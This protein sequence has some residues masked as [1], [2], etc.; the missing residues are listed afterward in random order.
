MSTK[1]DTLYTA[2]NNTFYQQVS[3]ESILS[4][5]DTTGNLALLQSN[6]NESRNSNP[7]TLISIKLIYKGNYNIYSDSL[8]LS[9]NMVLQGYGASIVADESTTANTFINIL[10]GSTN[11]SINNLTL[12]GNNKLL[13]GIYASRVNRVN[14]DK[15]TVSGTNKSG[16]LL[17]GVNSNTYNNE[18]T[19]TRCKIENNANAIDTQNVTQ[20]ICMDNTC[21]NCNSGIYIANSAYSTIINNSLSSNTSIGIFLSASS[22]ISIANNNIAFNGIG[23]TNPSSSFCNIVNNNITNSKTGILLNG[24]SNYL[25][26]NTFLNNLTSLIVSPQASTNNR[27]ITIAA[28]LTATNQRYFYPPTFNNFHNDTKII[29]NTN[30]TDIITTSNS[31][32]SIQTVYDNAVAANP[33]NTI[34][35]KLQAPIVYGDKTFIVNSNTCIVLQDCTIFLNSTTTAFSA[36]DK[37]FLSFSGGTINGLGTS[38]RYGMS[39]LN[40]SQILIENMT[41]TNFGPASSNGPGSDAILFWGCL[42]NCIVD[43]VNI[44]NGSARG[45]WIKGSSQNSTA[46]FTITN[47]TVSNFNQ[48]GINL[49]ITTSNSLVKFNKSKNNRQSGIFAEETANNNQIIANT[50]TSNPIGINIYSNINSPCNYNTIAANYCQN[51]NRGIRIGSA[52]SRLASYNFIFNNSLV[53]NT[54][55]IDSQIRG[56]DNYFSQQYFRDNIVNIASTDS[57]IFF[58]SP[59]LP[60]IAARINSDGVYYTAN[61]F[62]ETAYNIN[63]ISS[64]AVFSSEF[65]ETTINNIGNGLSK[66]ETSDGKVFIS[67][68]FDE[69]TD[70]S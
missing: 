56:S 69:V 59:F 12:S 50:C 60:I 52:T 34:V 44:S 66:S 33:N 23:I 54:T 38:G 31:L 61:Y 46:S 11:V 55:G 10:S 15:V 62:D 17:K 49:D 16:I 58:N 40:C 13:Y 68:Y 4:I 45:I 51:N 24:D 14:I 7:D 65:D 53:G 9:S 37:S 70:I 25:Y 64:T 32:S 42:P 48:F 63:K 36:I 21:S 22:R 1:L 6:I 27:V 57:A 18:I 8:R 19:V 39:F 5:M 2:P 43:N 47:N 41:L 26:N 35:L 3:G 28:P 67:G 20:F 29:N 30:R